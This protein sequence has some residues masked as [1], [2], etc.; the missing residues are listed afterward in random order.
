MNTQTKSFSSLT[1]IDNHELRGVLAPTKK[2]SRKLLEDIIDLIELSTTR[3]AK[4]TASRIKDGDRR[5]AW[6]PLSEV[7]KKAKLAK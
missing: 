1:L 5:K 7:M 2:I 3:E 4:L 6:I